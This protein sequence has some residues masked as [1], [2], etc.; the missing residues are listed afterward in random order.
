MKP[1]FQKYTLALF[2][3]GHVLFESNESRLKPLVEMAQIYKGQYTGC[4]LHDKIV[5]LASA[6]IIV[7]SGLVTELHAG[8]M[9]EDAR[10]FLRP[11]E[12]NFTFQELTAGI[13]NKERTEPCMMELKA[14]EI[15]D[16][17]ELLRHMVEIMG[18]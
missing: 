12:I 18:V 14:R 13:M 1:D 2:S 6:K 15:E 17:E 3:E 9:S 10:V 4:E 11:T 7:A 16:P 8:V 5:G